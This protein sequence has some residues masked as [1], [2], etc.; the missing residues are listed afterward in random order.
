M[1]NFD[2]LEKNLESLKDKFKNNLPFEHIVLDNFCDETALSNGVDQICSPQKL[3]SE[4]SR[5]YIFAKNKFEKSNFDLISPEFKSLKADLLSQ[6][7]SSWISKLT[8]QNIFIDDSFHGGGLH[9]GAQNSFLD[10]HVDFNYHPIEPSWF[11]NVNILLYLNKDWKQEY[12]GHL[13]LQNL[14]DKSLSMALIEPIFNRA[15]IMFTR[16]FTLHGYDSINFPEGTFRNSIAAYGYTKMEKKGKVR[17]T[18]WFPRKASF[19]KR[20]LGKHMPM[21]IKFKTMIFGSGT[22]KKEK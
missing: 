12:G 14:S 21:L 15:V 16:D 8:G 1:I 7:F 19:F 20:T 10:M 6:R 13:K 18:L 3:K 11:R 5:D 2:F 22:Q 17:T 9:Q 4:K